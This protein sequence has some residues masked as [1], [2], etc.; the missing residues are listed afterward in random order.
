MFFFISNKHTEEKKN[1]FL[2]WPVYINNVVNITH[3][4]TVKSARKYRLLLAAMSSRNRN[5]KRK[6]TTL[7]FLKKLKRE[8][9]HDSTIYLYMTKK[10][11]IS[12]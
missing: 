1:S 9:S 12:I 3:L 8:L 11:E 4:Y 2:F 7:S 5:R 10:Y 6:T